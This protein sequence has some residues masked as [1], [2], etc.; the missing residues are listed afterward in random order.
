MACAV[1]SASSSARHDLDA[2]LEKLKGGGLA[3]KPRLERRRG[4][5]S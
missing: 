1:A 2:E 4:P 3:Q 5:R